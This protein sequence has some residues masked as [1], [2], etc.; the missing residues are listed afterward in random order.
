MYWE[1]DE[2]EWHLK[3]AIR[4]DEKVGNSGCQQAVSS[5]SVC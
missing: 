1:E 4:V 5:C 2:E 3:N